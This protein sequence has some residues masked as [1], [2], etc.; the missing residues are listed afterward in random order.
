MT[1]MQA[2]SVRLTQLLQEKNMTLNQLFLQSGVPKSTICN[3][4]GCSYSSVKLRVLHEMCQGLSIELAEFFASP[5]FKEENLE[6]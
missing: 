2:V 5:L 6:P 4:L 3:V 1:L